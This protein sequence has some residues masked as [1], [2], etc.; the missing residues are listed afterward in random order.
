MSDNEDISDSEYDL[1][2][3]DKV[4]K[5]ICLIWKVDIT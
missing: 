4:F 5:M 1:M 2:K 3:R